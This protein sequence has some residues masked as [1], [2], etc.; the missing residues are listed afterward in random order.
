MAS[1]LGGGEGWRRQALAGL[2][3]ELSH[4]AALLRALDASPDVGIVAPTSLLYDQV[5]WRCA[6]RDLL[7]ALCERLALDGSAADSFAAGAMFWARPAALAPLAHAPAHLLDFECEAG[8]VDSTLHHA[9][10][11][12]FPLVAAAQGYRTVDAAQLEEF[13][14]QRA[15]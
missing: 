5:T 10:E 2:V 12:L 7:A 3:G 6:T 4:V 8:Q 9:Y 13:A 15:A 1:P 14:R 11:R